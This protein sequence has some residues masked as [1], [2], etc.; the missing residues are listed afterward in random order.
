MASKG[1]LTHIG[2]DAT[3]LARH[4]TGVGNYLYPILHQLCVQHPQVQFS[5]FSNA[6]I[7]FPLLP[8]V[9]LYVSRPKRRGPMW[10]LGQL[11]RMLS[12]Q[13][14]QVYWGTNGWLPWPHPNGIATVLTVHD[15][16]Y[17][18]AP[19]TLP[20]YSRWGR[21][22]L[23]PLSVRSAS[24]VIAVSHATA[25]DLAHIHRRSVD[26]VLHPVLQPLFCRATDEQCQHVRHQFS[27]PT[28][29][30]LCLG[31][32]EPRKNLLALLQAHAA[33]HARFPS[34]P[35]LILVGNS[36]WKDH[37]I[38]ATIE[39]A[40]LAG[41]VRWLSNVATADL[42]AIYSGCTAFI[43]PS[44]YEG[45]GIPLLEA[46][47]CGA[48]VVHGPHPSMSEAASSL[49]VVTG[50]TA[51]DIQHTLVQL[52]L[53]NLPLACRLPATASHTAH[54]AAQDTWHHLQLAWHTHPA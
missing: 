23:Q 22:W 25:A 8:N 39:E 10:Q 1:V 13:R 17:H 53:G 26:A 31:T 51:S 42:P 9:T 46:Q 4:R 15:L 18:F 50:T 2:V 19:A 47:L 34:L 38:R 32:I 43:M 5:L 21:R 20:W 36:G 49:G 37:S 6:D 40:Q 16:V 41:R 35:T 28:T 27:L 29:Y 44:L 54:Q 14:P 7:H 30:W 48:P 12:Q 33:V 45:F 3:P 11:P 52:H 24:R